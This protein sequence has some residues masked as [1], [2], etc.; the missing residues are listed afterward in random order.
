M[1][2]LIIS[3]LAHQDLTEILTYITTQLSAPQA[4]RDFYT[5]VSACYKRLQDN[6]FIYEACND[7]YLRIKNYR[8][9]PI[10]NYVL[11]YK[12]DPKKHLVNIYRFFYGKRDYLMLI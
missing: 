11:V 2:K 3:E 4:A 7:A 10:N 8:R 1:Y 5:E 6:P 9:A 12:I